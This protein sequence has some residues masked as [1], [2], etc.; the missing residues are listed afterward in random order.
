MG[1]ER[2]QNDSFLMNLPH[3]FAFDLFGVR[4]GKGY[5]ET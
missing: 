1:R 5:G 3:K 2:R 4:V